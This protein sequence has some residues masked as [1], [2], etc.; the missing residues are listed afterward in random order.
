[1]ISVEEYQRLKQKAEEARREADRLQGALAQLLRRLADE[2]NCKTPEEATELAK[3]L[4]A[5][6]GRLEKKLARQIQALK[7]NFPEFFVES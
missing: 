2:F 3:S 7:E 4:E 6:Q 5:Q 1:M